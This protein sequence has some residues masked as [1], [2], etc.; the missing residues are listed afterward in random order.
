MARR[1]HISDGWLI[2]WT[3]TDRPGDADVFTKLDGWYGADTRLDVNPMWQDGTHVGQ[4]WREGRKLTVAGRHKIECDSASVEDEQNRI[5][6]AIAGAFRSGTYGDGFVRV[7]EETTGVTLEARHVQLDGTPRFKLGGE[8]GPQTVSWE[9]PLLAGDPLLYEYSPV[10]YVLTAYTSGLDAGL[11][12]PLFDDAEGNTTGFLEF[13][14]ERDSTL[15]ALTNWGT[16]V[17]YPKVFIA[18]VFPS[19]FRVVIHS[20]QEKPWEVTYRS[21]IT[22]ASEV[23]VDFSGSVMVNGVDQSWAVV[24]PRW[25]GVE[26]GEAVT[27]TIEGVAGGVGMAQLL[28][29][30]AYL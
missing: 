13:S 25:G 16:A 9:L 6:R 1:L 30:P 19:G 21:E 2:S 4:L 11:E 17:T 18:G 12:Y 10:P 27:V 15:D 8:D 22:T 7:T 3:L 24:N 14:G 5:R 26:P 20:S 23:V 29:E 28:L